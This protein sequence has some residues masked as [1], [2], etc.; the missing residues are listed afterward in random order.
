MRRHRSIVKKIITANALS[1]GVAAF[2]AIAC[3]SPEAATSAS[4]SL[5]TAPAAA[6]APAQAATPVQAT[7]PAAAQ[8]TAASSVASAPSPAAPAAASPAAA[9]QGQQTYQIRQENSQ[10]RFIIDEVLRGSPF[11]VN[12]TTNQIS[13]QIVVDPTRPSTA[14]LGPIRIDARS[15]ATENSQRDRAIQNWVLQTAQYPEITFT[16]K[17]LMGLPATGNVGETYTFQIVGDLTVH[18]VTREET[19]DATL[20]LESPTQ[21]AGQAQTTIRYADYGINIPQVPIVSGIA[22]TVRLE[23]DFVATPA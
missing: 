8:S 17:Q 9:T 15:F 4:A 10:A 16:P 6:T 12:G 19:F 14:Q 23:M 3:S 2:G 21:L 13:G 18:G 22:E 11:T 20:T 1:V 5:Q 7:T